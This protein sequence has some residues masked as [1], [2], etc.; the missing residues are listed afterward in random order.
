MAWELGLG[1]ATFGMD[2]QGAPA[3][4]RRELH[5]VSLDRT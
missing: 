5:P 2:E 3:V 1:D 4:Q